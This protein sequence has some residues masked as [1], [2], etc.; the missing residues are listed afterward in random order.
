MKRVLVIEDDHDL[1]MLFKMALE[2]SLQDIQVD[3]AWNGTEGMKRLDESLPDAIVLDMHL[4]GVSGNEIYKSLEKRNE[5]HRVL[6]CSADVRIVN[7]YTMRGVN[8]VEKPVPM[9]ELTRRVSRIING[10]PVAG[11]FL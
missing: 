4:P 11:G 10:I 9:A 8:A 2:I 3:V 1:S 5:A 6:V 7:E